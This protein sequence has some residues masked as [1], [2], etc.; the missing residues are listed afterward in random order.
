MLYFFAIKPIETNEGFRWQLDICHPVAENC[1]FHRF[2][3]HLELLQFL[4]AFLLNLKG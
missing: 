4:D 3:Y 2:F 1:A